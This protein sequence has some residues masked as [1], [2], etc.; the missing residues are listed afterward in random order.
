VR[1]TFTNRGVPDWLLLQRFGGKVGWGL[2]AELSR[3]HDFSNQVEF[4]AGQVLTGYRGNDESCTGTK[5]V[6]SVD[7]AQPGR[8]IGREIGRGEAV[9]HELRAFIEKR[10][11]QRVKTEGERITEEAWRESERRAEARRR[12]ENRGGWLSWY[13]RLEHGYLVHLQ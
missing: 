4:C 13:R 6:Q 10:H 5:G 12:E 9:E 8:S 1:L 3:R 7:V 2:A 11:K